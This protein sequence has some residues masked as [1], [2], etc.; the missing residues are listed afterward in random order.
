MGVEG[1]EGA[2]VLVYGEEVGVVFFEDE[3]AEGFLL[4]G[5]GG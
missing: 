4:G 3:L 1:A 2:G 5:A